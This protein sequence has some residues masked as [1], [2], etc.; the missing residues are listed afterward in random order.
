MK[1]FIGILFNE[2]NTHTHDTWALKHVNHSL[3]HCF[4]VELFDKL[5]LKCYSYKIVVIVCRIISI[6]YLL[7]SWTIV[8]TIP[9]Q[10]LWGFPPF[11]YISLLNK[12]IKKHLLYILVT[13]KHPFNKRMRDDATHFHIMFIIAILFYIIIYYPQKLLPPVIPQWIYFSPFP[14]IIISHSTA[15]TYWTEKTPKNFLWL[16]MFVLC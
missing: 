1:L 6:V 10:Q 7:C 3:K 4:F 2:I 9:M 16:I 13:Q 11:K 15:I 8:W 12:N 5:D 14:I